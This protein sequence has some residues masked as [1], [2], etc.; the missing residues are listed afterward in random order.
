MINSL[1]P[2]VPDPTDV[3]PTMISYVLT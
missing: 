2:A 3:D 1:G